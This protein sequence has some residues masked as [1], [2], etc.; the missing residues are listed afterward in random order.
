[1]AVLQDIIWLYIIVLWWRVIFS[2]FPANA[3]HGLGILRGINHVAE[4]VTEPVLAPVRRLLPQPRV[5]GASLDLSV[6][7]VILILV[8]ISSSL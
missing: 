7:V 6:A 4:L 1:M 3:N 2:W 5:A 8:I